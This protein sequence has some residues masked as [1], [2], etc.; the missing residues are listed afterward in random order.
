MMSVIQRCESC[1]K[2]TSLRADDVQPAN[3]LDILEPA[4]IVQ[5]HPPGLVEFLAQLR[6]GRGFDLA[7]AEPGV[8][9]GNPSTH[10]QRL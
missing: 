1:G 4:D 5:E 10:S 9:G 8:L 6:R 7:I 2:E 3:I